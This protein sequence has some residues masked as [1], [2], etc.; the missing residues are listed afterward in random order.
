[1]PL[2]YLSQ[3]S[4]R[5][6]F[7]LRAESI[8]PALQGMFAFIDDITDAEAQIALS[9]MARTRLRTLFPRGKQGKG[10]VELANGLEVEVDLEDS[11]GAEFYVGHCNE[12]YLL[13]ALVQNI[14]ESAVVVDVGANF[15]L[16][17]L[18]TANI[19]C[20][21]VAFEA[22]PGPAECLRGNIERNGLGDRLTLNQRAVS[23]TV[24]EAEFYLAKDV[25]FSG[26][27]DTGRSE[28]VERFSVET[29][30]L[31]SALDGLGVEK[32]DFLKIDVEGAEWRVL[33][34]AWETIKRSEN[35]VIMMEYSFKNIAP[36]DLDRTN[37]CVDKLFASGL[38]LYGLDGLPPV[39]RSIKSAKDIPSDFNGGLIA[40]TPTSRLGLALVE[41]IAAHIDAPSSSMPAALAVTEVLYG[42][43]SAK[44]DLAVAKKDT[45]KVT[46]V[47][48]KA[49][50]RLEQSREQI[51]ELQDRAAQ[52]KAIAQKAEK[53]FEQSNRR[54]E[55][56]NRTI[57]AF[58]EMFSI[59]KNKYRIG[60]ASINSIQAEVRELTSALAAVDQSIQSGNYED[61]QMD[62]SGVENMKP[63]E[64]E[65]VAADLKGLCD[66]LESRLDESD[67]LGKELL[68][69]INEIRE[70]TTSQDGSIGAINE[71][72][73]SLDAS[74]SSL[75]LQTETH[76]STL[77][78]IKQETARI[79]MR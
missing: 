48:A 76:R 79:Q 23:D 28:F 4:P 12:A 18:H 50:A 25:S 69:A 8:D 41:R 32:V 13:N 74:V 9:R 43:R 53:K 19:G 14:D 56:R 67:T 58:R 35:L 21:T 64:L 59:V 2:S 42:L 31:D 54:V 34:G 7:G 60:N 6:S 62:L 77:K 11:F 78:V 40:T 51:L 68:S 71:R 55:A 37:A 38:S 24:G 72:L 65:K 22:A 46:S 3:G 63:G 75:E 49:E 39:L 17:A 20:R 57:E 70:Q 29:T 26:L 5:S 36:E 73:K 33:E 30:D 47:L 45:E 61:G 1:M 10:V 52:F 15:G 16:Y 44:D 27:R 66:R